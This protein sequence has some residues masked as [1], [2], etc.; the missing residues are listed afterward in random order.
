MRGGPPA[1]QRPAA[2]TPPPRFLEPPRLDTPRVSHH[3]R[4]M[5]PAIETRELGKI[6]AKKRTIR[7]LLTHPMRKPGTVRALEGVSFGVERG[8]IFGLLGPNGAGK[9][10]LLKILSCLI[11]PTTG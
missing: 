4:A 2:R 8:E 1:F 10:T 11:S 7:D 5:P 3:Y 6:F 9:T